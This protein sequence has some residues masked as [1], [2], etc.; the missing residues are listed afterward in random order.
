MTTTA[1]SRQALGAY[2]EDVAARLLTG[3]QRHGPARPQLAVRRGRARPGPARRRRAGRLR[4]QDPARRRVRVTARGRRRRPAG[5]AAPAGP[6]VGRGARRP[7]RR[8]PGRPGRRCCGRAA[9]RP[10]ST[11][12]GGWADAVRHQPHGRPRRRGRPRHRRPGR[13][14][15]GPGRP[16]SL[17]GRPDAALNESRDRCRM[18]IINSELRV[19]DSRRTTILLSPADLPKRGTHFDLAI[20]VARA[21]RHRRGA[22]GVARRRRVHRRAHPG[23]RAAL[24]SPGCCRW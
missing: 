20:A 19:A 24:A 21:R 6:A 11:T 15:V 3:E 10:W 1:A 17:V 18:A 16:P 12:C 23:R 5:A 7:P 13:R 8:R 2:G 14:L 4:G 9:A 22:A